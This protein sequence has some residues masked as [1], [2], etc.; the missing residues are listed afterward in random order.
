MLRPLEGEVPQARLGL[1]NE[2]RRVLEG[3]QVIGL[4]EDAH[5]AHLLLMVRAPEA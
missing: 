1:L 2:G 5:D 3:E 4:A